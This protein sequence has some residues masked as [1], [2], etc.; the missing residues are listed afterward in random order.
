MSKVWY[1]VPN[2]SPYEVLPGVLTLTKEDYLPMLDTVQNCINLF[3]ETIDWDGMWTLSDAIQR[4]QEDNILFVWFGP[5]EKVIGYYWLDECYIY[6]VFIHPSRPEGLSKKFMQT[7]FNYA[8]CDYFILYCDD[9]N[10]R[11]Q[12]FFEKVGGIKQSSYL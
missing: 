11:A 5:D 6:N 1:K 4:F 7:G 8:S 2:Y 10:I 3:N 12:K 9:W